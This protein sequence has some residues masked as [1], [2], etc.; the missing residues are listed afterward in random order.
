MTCLA[1]LL[2]PAFASAGRAIHLSDSR[3]CTGPGLRVPVSRLVEHLPLLLAAMR[4]HYDGDNARALLSQ[5]SK[6]YF[7]LVVPAAVAAALVLKRPLHMPW[8]DSV[9]LLRNGMPQALYLQTD[10]LGAVSDQPAVR[11]ASLCVEH[12]APLVDALAGAVRMA[13]RVLWSNVGHTL[14]YA[15]STS[16]DGSQAQLDQTFLLDRAVFFDTGLPNP[17]RQVIRYLTPANPELPDPLR[18]R[19]TCCLRYLLPGEKM[20]C[21]SCPMLLTLP[22]PAVAEQMRLLRA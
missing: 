6:Y 4:Q 20:L 7:S 19:R 12:L 9:L 17:L 22:A 21:S 8:E 2:P 15:L 1:T 5:W 13:A 11:Y 16:M 10:A 18:V 14:E 3:A